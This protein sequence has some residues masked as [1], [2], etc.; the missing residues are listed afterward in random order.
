MP[1]SD[2]IVADRLVGP[3]A[4]RCAGDCFECADAEEEDPWLLHWNQLQKTSHEHDATEQDPW[5]IHWKRMQEANTLSP[6]SSQPQTGAVV[7]KRAPCLAVSSQGRSISLVGEPDDE[8]IKVAVEAQL[9]IP[10]D[11]QNLVRLEGVFEVRIDR[12]MCVSDL[13]FT[14]DTIRTL[15]GNGSQIYDLLSDLVSGKVDP[16]KNL[17]PLDVVWHDGQWFSL[18]NRRLWALK[19][20][21]P[22]ARR[23]VVAHVRVH[24]FAT[25]GKEFGWK[26]TSTTGGVSVQ[27]TRSRSPSPASRSSLAT[28]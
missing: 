26:R 21:M 11:Q 27:I 1:F 6:G 15:F 12:K 2:P 9:G 17:E 28:T 19:A 18:S 20:F 8:Q 7:A 22:F 16:L 5:L 25:V 13:S 3:W 14:Q 10:K 23:S 4:W 24:D